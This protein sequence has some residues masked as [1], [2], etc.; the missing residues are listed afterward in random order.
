M[1]DRTVMIVEDTA[2]MRGFLK[3]LFEDSYNVILASDGLEAIDI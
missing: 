2:E 1:K 3:D